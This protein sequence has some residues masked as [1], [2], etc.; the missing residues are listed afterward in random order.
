MKEGRKEQLD[1]LADKITDD[2]LLKAGWFCQSH[3]KDPCPQP[4]KD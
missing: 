1:S 2:P 3:S 4:L